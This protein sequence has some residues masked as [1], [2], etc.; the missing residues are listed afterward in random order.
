MASGPDNRPTYPQN[1]NL[2]RWW[3]A[4]PIT[5]QSLYTLHSPRNPGNTLDLFIW[6]KFL[7][8]GRYSYRFLASESQNNKIVA[9]ANWRRLDWHEHIAQVSWAFGDQD[10]SGTIERNDHRGA[11]SLQEWLSAMPAFDEHLSSEGDCVA[12]RISVVCRMGSTG[13]EYAYRTFLNRVRK[14]WWRVKGWVGEREYPQ[15]IKLIFLSK[16]NER[17]LRFIDHQ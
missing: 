2:V 13:G 4:R 15:A 9:K 16:A 1:P 3:H 14:N 7:G 11:S 12:G 10:E 6:C 17:L 8:G 5:Q